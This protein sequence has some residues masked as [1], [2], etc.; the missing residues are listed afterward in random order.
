M[1]PE[2]VDLETE[3]EQL[4]KPW[5]IHHDLLRSVKKSYRDELCCF[6]NN[7]TWL[8]DFVAIF[9]ISPAAWCWRSQYQSEKVKRISLMGPT[10]SDWI[11]KQ[12]IIIISHHRLYDFIYQLS[13][14]F[15]PDWK[16]PAGQ[17]LMLKSYKQYT[18]PNNRNVCPYLQVALD[19]WWH[20]AS[21]Q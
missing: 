13:T 19:A 14:L 3:N 12:M 15:V 20:R 10:D 7:V 6:Y 1:N 5:S 18:C 2:N 11:R 4:S 9:K 17:F 8:E 21:W 16:R